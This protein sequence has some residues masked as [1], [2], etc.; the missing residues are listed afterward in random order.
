[1][2]V[3]RWAVVA[4]RLWFGAF[5]LLTSIYCLLTYVPFTY[6][7]LHKAGLVYS[8]TLFVRFHH[9]LYWISLGAAALTLR[10]DL[11]R[12]RTRIPAFGFLSFYAGVGTVLAVEPLLPSL[13]SDARSLV[14]SLFALTPLVWMAVIDW[15]AR[16]EDLVWCGHAYNQDPRV[17]RAAWQ[18]AVFLWLVYA[19]LAHARGGKG[20]FAA[21]SWSDQIAAHGWSL[22]SHL[23]AFMALFAALAL[24]GAIAGLFAAPA[25]VEF[26][27]CCVMGSA[28]LAAVVYQVA[29]SELSFQGWI[30]CGMAAALGIA[31][32]SFVAGLGLRLYRSEEPAVPSGIDV[33]LSPL[34]LG[35]ISWTWLRGRFQ[36]RAGPPRLITVSKGNLAPVATVEPRAA[37]I[38]AWLELSRYATLVLIA[39]A[40]WVL[41]TRTATLDW[42]FLVRKLSALLI[43][44][45]TF[46]VF[47]E[48]APRKRGLSTPVLLALAVLTLGIHQGF[49][50]RRGIDAGPTAALLDAYSGYDVSFRFIHDT[51][52]PP[53]ISTSFYRFL[54]DN[55]NIPRSTRVDPVDVKLVDQLSGPSERRPDIYV[56][57]LDSMRKDYLSPYNPAVTFTPSIQAFARESVVMTNAFTRYGGTGLSEPALWTGGALLHKQYVTPFYPMNSL[58]KL[59]DAE[60]YRLYLTR[61]EILETILGPTSDVVPLAVGVPEMQYDLCGV[62]DELTTR[63]GPGRD[64]QRPV[65]AYSL[66]QNLHVASINR[67][68]H[69][70]PAGESYPGFYAPYASR[71]K[72]IDACFGRFV[73]FLKKT[74]RYDNSIIVL[75]TDHGDQLGEG[76]KWGHAYSLT[77]EIVQIPLLIHLPPDLR[78]SL[79]VDPGTLAFLSDLTPTLYYLLGHRPIVRSEIFGRPLFT[80]SERE[81]QIYMRDSYLIASS[82]GPVYGLLKNRGA[83]LYVVDAVNFKDYLYDLSPGAKEISQPITER[84]RNENEA[85]IREHILAINRYYGFWQH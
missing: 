53:R 19:C 37:A 83:S 65:F 72:R 20:G 42:N 25:L 7:H 70:V 35:R 45:A 3:P 77:R 48:L 6:Q 55:T 81:Q 18:S 68:G 38:P 71:M 5:V 54:S 62:L 60:R 67:E 51:L 46:A 74:G 59:L 29:F 41:S 52:S 76:D 14:W 11:A 44:A 64:P 28:L 34:N 50:Y 47:F 13:G 21:W 30:A 36:R 58:Q 39:G 40:A 24:V 49:A 82:Y 10:E 80:Q 66:P 31:L 2:R 1:M 4:G 8:L 57:L 23:L 12:A 56:F 43:W 69:S 78:E 61:G 79:F 15:L 26:L 33:V 22:I 17:F 85:S 63:L 32:T 27:A 16:R 73:E 75:G 84:L 9:A